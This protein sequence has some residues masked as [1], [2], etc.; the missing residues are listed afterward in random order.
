MPNSIPVPVSASRAAREKGIAVMLTAFMLIFTIPIVGLAIDAGLLY[1]IRAKLS[2]ACDAAALATARNL[3]LGLTLAEQTASATA[4]GNAFFGANFPNG[5][6]GTYGTTPTISVS[7]AS[8]NTISVTTTASTTAPLYFMRYIGTTATLASSTGRASRRDVNL[9]LVLD[10]SGSMGGQPCRDMISASKTFVNMFVNGRD[11]LGMVSFGASVFNAYAPTTNFKNAST[12]LTAAIDQITCSG[13]TN[14]SQAYA[15]AYQQL[16]TLNQPLALN[17][18]VFFTDGVPTAFTAAFP[19]KTLPDQRRDYSGGPCGGTGVF[20]DVPKSTCTDDAGRLSTNPAWGT[21]APKSGVITGGNLGSSSGDTPG[22]VEPV[23]TTF[24]GEPLIAP[25][26]RVGCQMS[27]NSNRARY[28]LAYV[29]WTDANGYSTTGYQTGL[30]TF[31]AGH[32]YAGFLRLERPSNIAQIGINLADNAAAAARNNTALG[33]VT[34]TIGLGSNGG[35]D[36]T[37]LERMANDLASPIYDNTKVNGLYIYAPSSADLGNAF[38]RIASE[39]LRLA[40]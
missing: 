20:C 7:M 16:V 10:R 26:Q 8:M 4:R 35:V 11:K 34:Y 2:S 37:L 17:M 38:A 19:V 24:T 6:M 15:R 40:Q 33:V 14:T 36:D 25:S 29:P 9:I 12:P 23:A 5:Y 32:A 39:I 28:D 3:N 21:F 31:A 1:V 22:L 18:I 30:L 27:L 13:W